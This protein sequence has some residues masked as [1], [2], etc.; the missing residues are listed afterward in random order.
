LTKG[1]K[2]RC[3]CKFRQRENAHKSQGFEVLKKVIEMVQDIAEVESGPKFD[4]SNVVCKIDIKKN[5]N[6]K[7]KEK[8]E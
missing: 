8:Q 3:V 4:G 7:M 6:I 5:T 1:F 2:V